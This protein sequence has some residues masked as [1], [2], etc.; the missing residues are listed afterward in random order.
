LPRSAAAGG[1]AAAVLGGRL[2][3]FGGEAFD[4]APGR[5]L[6]VV[7]SYDPQLDSWSEAGRMPVPRHGLGALAIGNALWTIGGAERPSGVGTSSRM[8]F[9]R[10]DC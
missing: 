5:V 8:D 10:L 2:F 7:W 4:P 9:M 6:S 3:V 1:L